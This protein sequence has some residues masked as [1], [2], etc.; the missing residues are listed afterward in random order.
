MNI[1]NIYLKFLKFLH[2]WTP[3]RWYVTIYLHDLGYGGSEEGGWYFDTYERIDSEHNRVFWFEAK[4]EQYAEY[5]RDEVLPKLN[6][7][8]RDITSVLS[9]GR[10]TYFCEDI[11]PVP[12]LPEYRPYYE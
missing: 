8:R 9:E 2:K 5:L 7:G 3:R 6:E 12:F 10:F 11:P 4:A 1:P